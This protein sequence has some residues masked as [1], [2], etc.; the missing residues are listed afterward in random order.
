MTRSRTFRQILARFALIRVAIGTPLLLVLAMLAGVAPASA[1]PGTPAKP[2]VLG[3]AAGFSVLASGVTSTGAASVLALDL[4]AK[5]DPVGFP[6]GVVTGEMHIGDTAYGAADADR[7]TAYESVT[8][9]T[10]GIGFSGDQA[11]KTYT[12]GLYST[13]AAITNTG[14]IT[15]DA[16]GDPSAIFVFQIGAALSS[17]ASTKVVLTNGAL[18]NNVYWQVAG[19]VALGAG[20]KW[21]GTVLGAGVVSFG[22][23][24]SIKGRVLAGSTVTLANT[25]VT[26]PVDDFDAPIVTIDPGPE[27]STGDTTPRISGTTNEPGSPLVTVK[28]GSQVLTAR[29][30]PRVETETGVWTGGLWTVSAGTLTAGLHKVVASV[31]DPSGNIGTARQDLTVDT[32]APVVT[33][34]GGVTTATNDTTPTFS[35]TTDQPGAVVTVTVEGQTLTTIASDGEW[36]VTTPDPLAETAHLVQAFVTDATDR[37]GTGSQVLTV[38]VTV[39]VLTID[40]GPSRS[41]SDTSP[42]IYGTTAEKAGT[43]VQVD[44]DGQPLIATVLSG[45]TW[46]VSAQAVVSGTYSVMATIT[47]AAGNTGFMIQV[48]QIGDVVTPPAGDPPPVDFDGG[49]TKE[50]S[51]TTPT[52]SGTTTDLGNPTVVV[53]VGG[54]TLTTTADDSGA[55][56]VDV[57][58]LP[59]GPHTVVVRVIDADGNVISTTQ[60][61]TV[62]SVTPSVDPPVDPPVTTPV[63]PPVAVAPTYR[64]DAELRLAKGGYVGKGSYSV[65]RQRVSATLNGSRAKTATFQSRLTNRGNVAD[66]LTVRGTKKSRQFTVVYMHGRKNV[67][68]AVLKGT[69]RTGTLQAGRSVTLTVKIT[70]VK[71]VKKGS[72]RTFTIRTTSATDRSKTDTVAA[73]ARVTRS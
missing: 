29:A 50:T 22:E 60:E 23:G 20:A 57:E 34:G 33:I 54:Q 58:A 1:A 28:I 47:D 19:A 41:T 21:A 55:W 5:T 8:A 64:P 40:G 61:L 30:T 18:A 3:S 46:G 13:A 36:T 31:A 44:L 32:S 71:R 24:A 7:Q 35:G 63:V 69:Y 56:S 65:S 25:P 6:P 9:Q 26:Q 39:P 66:R 48:L 16:A 12:P 27:A 72:T 73:V 15:L 53:T 45:G 10:G 59:E 70:K 68:A 4:G 51:D 67:T 11:G 38:D 43:T 2:V 42:W 37:V 14:T 52:I 49:V 62:S 17:A